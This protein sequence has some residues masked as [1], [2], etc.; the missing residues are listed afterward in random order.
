MIDNFLI[1]NPRDIYFLQAPRKTI[2]FDYKKE[3]IKELENIGMSRIDIKIH[4][5]MTRVF[6]DDFP[7]MDDYYTMNDLFK[8]VNGKSAGSQTG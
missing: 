1:Y 2:I 3:R 5:F 7:I 8:L 4:D 6:G